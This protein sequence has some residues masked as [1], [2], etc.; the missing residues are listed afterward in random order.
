MAS[1]A[2]VLKAR[3]VAAVAAL[4]AAMGVVS[5]GSAEAAVQP[6]YARYCQSIHPGSFV[7]RM[8]ATGD[9]ICTQR[10]RYQLRHYRINLARA[11]QLTT[12][13][14]RYRN[15]GRGFVQCA[16]RR[17][18]RQPYTP[19]RAVSVRGGPNYA[20]YCQLTHPGSF[21]NRMRA[22]GEYIC[23]QRSRY[24]LRH[25]R[26]NLARACQLTNGSTRYRNFG[27]GFVQCGAR[28]VARQPYTPRRTAWV[29]RAPNLRAYCSRQYPG[30]FLNRMRTTGEY[31]C[32][33]RSRYQLRHHRINMAQACYAS[34]RTTR[35]SYLG[36]NR[37]NPRCQVRV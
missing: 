26:I 25:Y 21:V 17:T 19:S 29:Q 32:T 8:R 11:C 6:N 3:A 24:Q 5:A 23:T 15:F 37:A 22:T 34:W 36:G 35:Y 30:S 2:I 14:T 33:Q 16:N 13:N 18:V 4:A 27:R 1:S 7:N 28:R 9:Y 31:I 12:G 20:R 10:S